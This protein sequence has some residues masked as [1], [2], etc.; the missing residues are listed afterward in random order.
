[1][2]DVSGRKIGR[3]VERDQRGEVTGGVPII[4]RVTSTRQ[5]G[6]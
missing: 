4:F 3:E 1:M 2:V 6:S 5:I